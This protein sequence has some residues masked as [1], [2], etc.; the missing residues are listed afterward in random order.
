LE[1][2]VEP[3][4]APPP[5]KLPTPTERVAAAK[6][7]ANQSLFAK[8]RARLMP[9]KTKPV[10]TASAIDPSRVAAVIRNDRSEAAA[11]VPTETPS[12]AATEA[13]AVSPQPAPL[14]GVEADAIEALVAALGS[15]DPSGRRVAMVGTRRNMGTTLAAISLARALAAQGRVVLVDLALGSPNLSA[16]ASDPGA[17]GLSDLVH[18][19]ASFGEI[20]T[21]DRHSRV[22][23]IT[24][25]KAE[26]TSG[27]ILASQRLAIILEA[28]SRS[29]DYV[30]L[31]CGALPAIA[32]E[33][34]ARL[35]PR[36]VLVADD[37]DSQKTL[38]ARERLL[39]AGF[40]DV[41]VLV[42]S[43]D[44]PEY[45]AGGDRAAA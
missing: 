20:I 34:F 32:P 9:G 8:V 29:Y 17:P 10:G 14:A 18:G 15:A 23:L 37:V 25:G 41:S 22:H 33:E 7:A 27:A 19:S 35:A 12:A 1:A 13:P 45:D 36:A 3:P 39:A 6:A 2:R 30:V 16:I 38:S 28:L 24:V 31:D 40:P 5:V 42:P 44:G 21:R 4:V 26:V 43:P 11:S